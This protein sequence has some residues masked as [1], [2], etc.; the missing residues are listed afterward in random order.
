MTDPKFAQP[1]RV[2]RWFERLY[3]QAR[4]YLHVAYT[5]NWAGR[6]FD[7]EQHGI[8]DAVEYVRSID[9]NVAPAGIYSR[10]T[11]LHSPP[12]PDR[13][14]G[15]TLTAS[16]P[17]LWADVDI[18]GPG[19][20][21]VECAGGERCTHLRPHPYRILPLPPTT[22]DAISLIEDS[23]LPL[24]SLWVHSGGGMYPIWLL[25]E[26]VH[27]D[28]SGE[29][30]ML[31]GLS[32]DWQRAIWMLARERGWDYG[33]GVGDLA[34]IL[35]VPGTWNRKTDTPAPCRVVA[36]NHLTYTIGDLLEARNQVRHVLPED[37]GPEGRV[38]VP[39][40]PR[41]PSSERPEGDVRP[42]DDFI[43]RADWSDKLL[44]GGLGWECVLQ[45]GTYREWLRQ[46]ASGTLTATTGRG[47]GDNLWVFSTATLFPT[48]RAISKLEAFRLIHRHADYA[49]A[50]RA[51]NA[52]GFGSAA[53]APSS[54][55][56][57]A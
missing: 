8:D 34:R 29:L 43:A 41:R 5:G 53:V 33:F 20:K 7:L 6:V 44:L 24:P 4:G 1:Q 17:A 21:H 46:N 50:A 57:T 12:G 3:G 56:P 23:P 28:S 27:P 30:N 26:P 11:T 14:G 45:R 36:S 18:A 39:A 38:H 51:L 54:M 37:G 16:L 13:R 52:L 32:A 19:H 42:G 40:V 9:A 25:T 55:P 31:A 49:S 2:A 15:G 47:G 48:E 35:R 10:I 22:R